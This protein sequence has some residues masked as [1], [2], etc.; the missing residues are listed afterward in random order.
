MQAMSLRDQRL[1]VQL[2]PQATYSELVFLLDTMIRFGIKKY[3]LD[4]NHGPPIFY[5]FTVTPL[6]HRPR[7]IPMPE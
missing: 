2:G 6:A 3:V 7:R 1:R 5:A 4:V